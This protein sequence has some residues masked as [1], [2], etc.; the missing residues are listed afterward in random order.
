[1]NGCHPDRSARRILVPPELIAA[2]RDPGGPS[3]TILLQGVPSVM[4]ALTVALREHAA[5]SESEARTPIESFLL[6]IGLLWLQ[7]GENA[8]KQHGEGRSLGIPPLRATDFLEGTEFSW[9]S[10][11]D[12]RR[13]RPS[14][15]E[16]SS[17]FQKITA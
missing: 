6:V 9:R 2:W 14:K 8:L 1:M 3:L 12:D 4:V 5:K 10:G 13:K 15:R 7:S 16:H 11:R 17:L